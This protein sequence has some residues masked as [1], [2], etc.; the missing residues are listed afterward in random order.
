[1][2]QQV[3]VAAADSVVVESPLPGGIGEV[4]RFLLNT[5][6]P[7]VQIAGVFVAA[8]VGVLVLGLV[9]RRRRAIREWLASRTRTARVVLAA[10]ALLLIAGTVGAGAATWNY[11]Q[12]E[13]AFCSGCHIMNPAFQKF[14]DVE[15]KHGELSCH[16][17]HQQSNYDS[18]WQLYLWVAER[19]DK[20]GGHA[21][22]PNTVC[23][24]CH[25]TGDTATWQ[26]IAATAG[27]RVHLES[28]SGSLKN[29]QCVTCHGVEIH[30]FR[31]V[32]E[33]CG[34]SG[35][36]KTGDTDIMIGKMAE[37]TVRHC[38][39][40]HAFTADVPA[41]ATRD[42]AR[43][44]LVPGRPQCLG[45]HEMQKVLADFDE[46]KDP[47]GGK[48]GMCHNPHIQKSAAAA[49]TSCTTA[50]C[51]ANWRD[52]PFHVGA[53]HKR[54]ASKCL[55]CHLPHRAKVDA[56]NCEACHMSVRAR[57]KLRPPIPF[58]T[59]RAL[60]RADAT[61]APPSPEA[62]Y[63]GTRH[64]VMTGS[65]RGGPRAPDAGEEPTPF[66]S[67]GAAPAADSAAGRL[68]RASPA[69]AERFPH[70]CTRSWRASSAMRP[71]RGAAASPSSGRV[72][73]P[74]ATIRRQ[75]RPG[76]RRAIGPGRS[77][78]RRRRR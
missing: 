21:K 8:A 54:I 49:A 75:L 35:C 25:V 6:P 61:L 17:C 4:V 30:R 57:G 7:W 62:P 64:S 76:A 18:A 73:A 66:E 51:H 40:C 29:L 28:D 68:S 42:S 20:I 52:E 55:T 5:V 48:C 47:H 26:R 63:P 24:T 71:G 34:Q 31:P 12:H 72:A 22:V 70:A 58:D 50:G 11:T 59:A 44:T 39:S 1:M 74:S 78:P 2:L 77:R 3:H 67:P 38:T 37:Q 69:S 43:S 23:E 33:T 10:A 36:H 45:C 32:S 27:H 46:G 65:G 56:S 60:R 19:P 15:N 9:F 53:S 13:N 14:A 41:L 16:A